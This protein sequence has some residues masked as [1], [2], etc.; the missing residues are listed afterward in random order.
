MLKNDVFMYIDVLHYLKHEYAETPNVPQAI[1]GDLD[2]GSK[3]TGLNQLTS[4]PNPRS[5]I[6]HKIWGTAYKKMS[7]IGETKRAY[8]AKA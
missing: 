4:S 6:L 7:T 3:S 1:E 2:E 8:E 5:W